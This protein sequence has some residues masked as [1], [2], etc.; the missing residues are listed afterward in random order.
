MTYRQALER[1]GNVRK[2]ERGAL[3]VKYGTFDIK[4]TNTASENGKRKGSYLRGFTIFN[5][6]QIEGIEF[7][8]AQHVLL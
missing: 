8:Q 5:A 7:P 6:A 3:V 4:E 1:G 2:G